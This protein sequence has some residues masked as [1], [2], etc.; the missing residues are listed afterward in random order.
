MA[1]KK[2]VSAKNKKLIIDNKKMNIEDDQKRESLFG[3]YCLIGVIV[4]LIFSMM[5]GIKVLNPTN[6][7]WIFSTNGDIMQHYVGWEAYKFGDWTFPIGLTDATSFPTNISVIYTDSIP[8]VA[9]FFKIFSFVL[10]KTFQY[11][12]LYGLVCFIL[13]AIFS[14]KIV[15]KFTNSKAVIVVAS[16]LFTVIPAMIFRIFYHT[17]LASQWLIILALESL[18]LYDEFKEGK[19][20]YLFWG[21]LGFLISSIHLYYLVMCGIVLV[22]FIILDILNTKKIKKS[23]ISLII[24][25]SV[26]LFTI[27]IFGGFVNFGESDSFGFGAFSYNLNGL[28]NSQGWSVF[29]EEL[30]MISEQYEG[31]SYLGLGVIL[32]IFIAFILTIIW[33]IKDK[34]ILSKNKNLII[35][36]CI[37]SLLSTIVAISPKV[38]FGEKLLFELKLPEFITDV[39]SIFR[40]TGRF[41]WPVIYILMLASIIVVIKRLNW[42][43][44]VLILFICLCV[45]FV[46]IGPV[47][48]DSNAFFSQDFILNDEYNLNNNEYLQ[49]ISSNNNIKLMVF[50]SD[51][52]YDSD[53]FLY[54]DW[55]LNNGIK[56]NKIHFARTSFDEILNKNTIKFLDKKDE[57]MV[58][59]FTSRKEC[60]NNNLICYKFI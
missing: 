1:K 41:I 34:K 24:F 11:L 8:I 4:I 21:L 12:G 54:S 35:S 5:Y 29:F 14:A 37:I 50:A 23:I 48:M 30:P 17:A 53:K 15:S 27:Y 47:L 46:D 39:W 18:F 13:Q 49:K 7:N 38:Y 2:V 32:L 56:T 43:L 58:F 10:P 42:K 59:L 25:I 26:S 60:F 44:S 20:C 40:S 36:L 45:Q 19:K 9:L 55:A 51:D 16:L 6:V 52:F 3:Y 33:Y 31:F 22:G 57:S 28:F